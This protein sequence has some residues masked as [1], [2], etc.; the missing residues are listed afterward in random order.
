MALRKVTNLLSFIIG[1]SNYYLSS[2]SDDSPTGAIV[3]ESPRIKTINVLS[4]DG[5]PTFTAIKYQDEIKLLGVAL[6]L[7]AFVIMSYRLYYFLQRCTKS[8]SEK[9]SHCVNCI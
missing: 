1:S 4:H 9:P 8:K 6:F 3:I 2:L 5:S 7:P